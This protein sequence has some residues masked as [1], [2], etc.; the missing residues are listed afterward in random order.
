M[1][2]ASE[3]QNYHFIS[4]RWATSQSIWIGIQFLHLDL[5]FTEDFVEN[6]RSPRWRSVATDR[7]LVI[8]DSV[9]LIRVVQGS[10]RLEEDVSTSRS[11]EETLGRLEGERDCEVSLRPAWACP[12][13]L[14]RVLDRW[15][16]D[17]KSKEVLRADAKCFFMREVL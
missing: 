2:V 9:A 15:N 10:L 7:S 4:S 3:P 1:T 6:V 13:S 11:G 8:H 5:R 16:I 12:F 17:S 14:N